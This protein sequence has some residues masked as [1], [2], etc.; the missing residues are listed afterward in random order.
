MER[1]FQRTTV[2]RGKAEGAEVLFLPLLRG[3]LISQRSC[4]KAGRSGC[5]DADIARLDNQDGARAG[6]GLLHLGLGFTQMSEGAD[7]AALPYDL[8]EQDGHGCRGHSALHDRD[9]AWWRKHMPLS[10]DSHD[11]GRPFRLRRLGVTSI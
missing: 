4:L 7:K 5:L 10:F 1:A 6:V 9:E 2:L 8:Q 3:R 11:P